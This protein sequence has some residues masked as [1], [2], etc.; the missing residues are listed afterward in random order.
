MEESLTQAK[1]YLTQVA[2]SPDLQGIKVQTEVLAGHPAQMI[3]SFAQDHPVDL[4]VM[5]SH[6]ASGFKR[7]VMG[8]VAQKVVRHSSVPTLV[9]REG[10]SL[11][12]SPH[13]EEARSVQVMVA[14]DGSALAE[15]ALVPAAYLSAALSAPA[16]GVLRLVRVLPI[17]EVGDDLPETA[18]EERNEV[19]AAAR[20]QA[21]AAGK[22]YLQTVEHRLHEGDLASLHLVSTSSVALNADVAGTLIEL[23]ESGEA[24]GGEE[25]FE[26]CDIIAM[27]TH[28]RGGLQR[29]VMGSVTERVLGATRLPLLIVRPSQPAATASQEQTSSEAA[30]T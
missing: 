14:L 21:T 20:M 11:P 9:L 13:P 18:T 12:I 29:W 22:D 4:I 19:A 15:S 5:C 28:G 25:H 10:G 23:A 7:W 8:S 26:G 6:G 24:A 16:Q 27:A 17:P 1:D 30:G 3:L 2:S